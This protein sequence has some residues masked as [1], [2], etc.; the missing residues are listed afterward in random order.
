MELKSEA[1]DAADSSAKEKGEEKPD[2][3]GTVTG[4]RQ[5]GDGQVSTCLVS[6]WG[7]H[8]A[9][10]LLG[11]V[12][13]PLSSRRAQSL[14]RTKWVKKALSIWMMMK[15]GKIQHIYPG[16][17]SSL[18]MIFEDKLRKR[19]FGNSHLLLFPLLASLYLVLAVCWLL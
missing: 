15:I 17:G 7:W 14:W 1:N 3:K 8:R 11:R 9:S 6:T 2:T 18:S 12:R 19:K 10:H 4:E 13:S 16:K 5:S